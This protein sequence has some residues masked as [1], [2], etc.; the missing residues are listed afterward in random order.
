M[1]S[2][3]SQDKKKKGK[4]LPS[5]ESTPGGIDGCRD[6][7]GGAWDL[8][9]LSLGTLISRWSLSVVVQSCDCRA[10]MK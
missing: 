2:A 9:A 3:S 10:E 8:L 7:G 5:C 1:L 4:K 6:E